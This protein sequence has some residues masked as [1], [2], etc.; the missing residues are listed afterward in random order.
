MDR[1]QALAMNNYSWDGKIPEDWI[2]ISNAGDI[3]YCSNHGWH[4]MDIEQF[5]AM[6][7]MWSQCLPHCSWLDKKTETHR[8]NFGLVSTA[9]EWDSIEK[10]TIPEF[11]DQY[12]GKYYRWVGFRYD[13]RSFRPYLGSG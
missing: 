7:N 9:G 3:S 11:I 8:V 13:K 4:D 12:I 10:L 6:C 5:E 2:K 1:Y